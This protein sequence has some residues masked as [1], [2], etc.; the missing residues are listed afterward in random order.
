[1][2]NGEFKK[3]HSSLTIQHSPF[4]S[5][6]RAP[7]ATVLAVMARYPAVGEV[8]TR[9][10]ETIGASRACAL[11]RAFLQD[12]EARFAQGPRSFVWMFH[13]PECDF[14]ALVAP[15]ARC[16]PQVGRDLGA[17]LHNCFRQLCDAGFERV[18]VI[19]ADVPHVRDAW[20]DEAEQ[21]L[22]TV[23]VV[24][25][26]SDDGGYYLVAMRAAHDIFTGVAMGTPRVL[27]ET[28]A[29]AARAG[30]RVHLLPGSFDIDDANDLDRL[31]RLLGDEGVSWLPRTA[32]VL[33]N[34]G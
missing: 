23:D 6:A 11:Y 20:L 27:A 16:L 14:A 17:R 13:P 22:D 8:K 31:Q 33:R 7:R 29:T 15:G 19:G 25:G 5:T 18:I 12:I 28:L 26:P 10:A 32:E 34:R 24:L 21:Y 30:L 9:L 3:R 4:A 1:M 2:V